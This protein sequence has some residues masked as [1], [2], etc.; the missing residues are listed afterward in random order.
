MD[1]HSLNATEEP[2]FARF[3]P[4]AVVLVGDYF[5]SDHSSPT[6]SGRHL[7]QFPKLFLC[8]FV[9]VNGYNP[10]VIHHRSSYRNPVFNRH[11]LVGTVLVARSAVQLMRLK[12]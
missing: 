10:L 1:Q 9:A 4:L 12:H 6:K 7:S 2:S 3:A 11:Q 5:Y 8:P